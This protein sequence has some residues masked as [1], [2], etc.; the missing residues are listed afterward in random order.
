MPPSAYQLVRST[1]DEITMASS[2][3]KLSVGLLLTLWT[4][5]T[6]MDAVIVGLNI[7]YSVTERRAWWKRRFVA[8]NLT[9]L[10]AAVAGLAAL[11]A[12]FG[13]RIGS[14]VATQYGY[15]DMFGR[16]WF[17]LQYGFPPLFVFIMLTIIYRF[18]PNIRAHGWQALMPG[19]LVG[20]TLW[21]LATSAFRLYLSYFDSYS[22]TYGSL[23]TAIVLMLWL[24]MCGVAILVG[25]EV[26]SEIR[27]AAAAAGAP[28]AK[29][30]L[31]ADPD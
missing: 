26:N 10:L 25:A 4:A 22:K 12:L 13:G 24:Y 6:G 30:K 28:T 1:V 8:M 18:A 9:I 27:K 19:A 11:I 7:A 2:G 3:G 29:P 23:G 17:A 5:S 15:G 14:F 16:F 31:E 20:V 21:M